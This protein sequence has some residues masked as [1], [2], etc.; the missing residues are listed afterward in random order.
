MAECVCRLWVRGEGGGVA[1]AALGV[2]TGGGMG[3]G[4][5]GGRPGW[6]VGRW[7]PRRRKGGGGF[8]VTGWPTWVGLA[9]GEGERLPWP[10]PG[11]SWA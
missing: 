10:V 3:G 1:T 5:T 6:V 2:R 9:L 7:R 4:V 11:S 8:G